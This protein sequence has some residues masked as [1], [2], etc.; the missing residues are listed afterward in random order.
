MADG[1]PSRVGYLGASKN[2]AQGADTLGPMTMPATV[3]PQ[4]AR[5]RWG[6]GDAAWSIAGGTFAAAF[7]GYFVSVARHGSDVTTLDIDGIDTLVSGVVQFGVML[8]LLWMTVGR[9]G[10][11]LR[12][13][14]GLVVRVREAYWMLVG[15]GASIAFGIVALPITWLWDRGNHATQAIGDEVK[16]SS[17]MAKV[18][19][20]ILVV[21]IAPF[22][23]EAVFRGVVLRA[24]LRRMSAAPAVIVSGAAF[25]LLHLIDPSTLPGIPTLFTMGMVAALLAVRSGELSRSIYFH[26]GFNALAVVV[27][28][29]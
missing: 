28:L 9:R 13:E 25:S 16:A 21:V 10:Y 18:G 20:V 1:A 24:A 17:S 29:Q 26:A 6:F 12:H 14:I 8:G 22:V 11:G 15:V 7:I 5:P 19:L 4:R 3:Q 2:P 27:L 23:E